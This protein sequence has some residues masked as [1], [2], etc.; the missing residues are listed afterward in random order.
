[1]CGGGIIV[2][3]LGPLGVVERPV[4]LVTLNPKSQ[5]LVTLNHKSQ[6]LVT[7]NP[8]TLCHAGPLVRQR[9]HP[10]ETQAGRCMAGSSRQQ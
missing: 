1:M 5:Y 10:H 9:Y 7:L 3:D 6:Y 8:R 2:V 4:P